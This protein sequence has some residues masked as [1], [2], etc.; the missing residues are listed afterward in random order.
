MN[1]EHEKSPLGNDQERR[2]RYRFVPCVVVVSG[3]PGTGKTTFGRFL[4]ITSNFTLLD[5]DNIREGID[6]VRKADPSVRWLP[7]DQE[8][9]IMVQ[10]YAVMCQR[11]EELAKGGIP[12]V[13]AGTFS[14]DRFKESLQALTVSLNKDG[15]PLRA[16]HLTAPTEE[17]ESRITRQKKQKGTRGAANADSIKTFRWIQGHFSPIEFIE[18]IQIDTSTYGHYRKILD[19]LNDLRA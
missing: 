11:A 10:S 13:I 2:E 17:I 9:A 4:E 14:R 8:L 15:I 18:V 16:F 6:E 7:P 1:N 5:V 3:L 12:I 19:N